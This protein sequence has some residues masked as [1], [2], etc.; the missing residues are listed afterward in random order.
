M[1]EV[2]EN[3]LKTLVLWQ[4]GLYNVD[5]RINWR[6]ENESPT[7]GPIARQYQLSGLKVLA[8]L[9]LHSP[10]AVQRIHLKR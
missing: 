5:G 7:L 9:N 1:R 2:W 10:V 3:I 4:E 8:A 6:G